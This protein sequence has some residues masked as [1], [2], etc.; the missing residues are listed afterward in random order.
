MPPGVP[1]KVLKSVDKNQTSHKT[2]QKLKNQTPERPNVDFEVML[3][4][5]WDPFLHSL[6]HFSN[7]ENLVLDQ[8]Y[9]T[10][11]SLRPPET[12]PLRIDF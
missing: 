8:H 4:D 5:C 11:A 10:L 1:Q 12:T 2:S 9:G 7:C 3:D 6:S